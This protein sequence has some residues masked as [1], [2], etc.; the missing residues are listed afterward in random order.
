MPYGWL[1]TALT[2]VMPAHVVYA[3]VDRLPAGFS[4][5]WLNDILRGQLGF[6]GCIFSDD[7]SMEGARRIA[8]RRVSFSEAAVAAL[9]AGC[10]MAMLC[11][12][13][14][15]SGGKGIDMLLEDME[16]ARVAGEWQPSERSEQRRLALLPA[17]GAPSWDSLMSDP[18]Y[19][20][21]LALI[22]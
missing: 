1:S 9:N 4:P 22:P 10:D 7:L 11:N 3:K 13:S 2:A 8:G 12:E 21:A 18:N 14:A 15:Q 17:T 20:H 6:Q 16:A 19:M 5:K